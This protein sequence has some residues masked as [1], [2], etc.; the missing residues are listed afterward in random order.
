MLVDHPCVPVAQQVGQELGRNPGRRQQRCGRV[1]QGGS[2][3]PLDPCLG[4]QPPDEPP[5]VARLQGRADFGDELRGSVE[6]IEGTP[7]AAPKLPLTPTVRSTS[8]RSSLA[9]P[10]R[11]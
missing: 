5:K 7:A 10:C 2:D 1:P 8:P 3:N 6:I 4:R 9:P 11:P